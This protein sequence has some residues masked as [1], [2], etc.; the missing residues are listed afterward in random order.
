MFEYLDELT[1]FYSRATPKAY[2]VNDISIVRI[3]ALLGGLPAAKSFTTH[4][5]VGC[6][7]AWLPVLL[8]N[9][10]PETFS[11]GVDLSLDSLLVGKEIIQSRGLSEKIKLYHR[12]VEELEI[13][14][15]MCDLVTAC[16]SLML[17][18]DPE[19]FV[20]KVSILLRPGGVL[21]FS[22]QTKD[23]FLNPYK[24]KAAREVLGLK[25]PDV[26]DCLNTPQVC[27]RVCL[28]A[29]FG[30]VLV[31]EKNHDYHVR[32]ENQKWFGSWL[33]P[34]NP[35]RN[36]SDAQRRDL[37]AEFKH[38]LAHDAVDG[39]VICQ[40]RFLYVWATKA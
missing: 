23:S 18:R 27:R 24:L 2:A 12:D 3:E 17:L 15:G 40:R 10:H 1:A 5:D 35:L 38:L 39:K 30:D 13:L 4:L 32:V 8:Q 25:L 22:T 37:H 19:G 31:T 26:K 16:S 7:T 21:A 34:E 33:H 28:R 6:G 9:T 29:G 11:H 36:I 14:P 20:T